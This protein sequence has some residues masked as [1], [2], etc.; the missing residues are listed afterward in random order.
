MYDVPGGVQAEEED[1]AQAEDDRSLAQEE[2]CVGPLVLVGAG[3]LGEAQQQVQQEH[4]GHARQVQEQHRGLR[5]SWF[6]LYIISFLLS[7][8]QSTAF[9]TFL[10]NKIDFITSFPFSEEH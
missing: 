7:R 1:G 4:R 6:I 3:R 2:V 5:V 9:P 8:P 10:M